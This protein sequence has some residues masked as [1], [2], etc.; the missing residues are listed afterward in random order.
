ML[1]CMPDRPRW[2]SELKI[3]S[4]GCKD[5]L[6]LF[7]VIYLCSWCKAGQMRLLYLETV[8]CCCT[9]FE[10]E[11]ART[12]HPPSDVLLF[13]TGPGGEDVRLKHAAFKKKKK[14]IIKHVQAD[15]RLSHS[16]RARRSS[17]VSFA[18][19]PAGPVDTVRRV[20]S[21]CVTWLFNDALVSVS[22]SL[23]P[24]ATAASISFI[25]INSHARNSCQETQRTSS[26]QV[27]SDGLC[28]ILC[29]A[30][31]VGLFS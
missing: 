12:L 2:E 26:A 5:A 21:V 18:L 30:S 31:C 20:L 28:N 23:Q 25:V 8:R 4:Y 15:A 16:C 22:C 14:W 10:W 6:L 19:N 9:L 27:E 29:R 7:G 1:V 17:P 3:C 24:L 11:G 13:Q